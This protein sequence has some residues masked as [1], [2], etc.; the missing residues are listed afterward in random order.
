MRTN[1]VLLQKKSSQGVPHVGNIACLIDA[2]LNHNKSK[3]HEEKKRLFD[4]TG[5]EQ[6]ENKSLQ[7]WYQPW[8][9]I[10]FHRALLNYNQSTSAYDDE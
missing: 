7:R 4:A 9:F 8:S 6:F 5:L 3:L 1:Q 10:P 2:I